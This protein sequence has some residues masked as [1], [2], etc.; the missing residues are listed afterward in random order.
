MEEMTPYYAQVVGIGVI[1]VTVHCIGMCGPIMASL[2]AATG[3]DRAESA[4]GRLWRA[5][6]AVLSYQGGRAVVYAALGAAAGAVGAGAQALIE[7]VAKTAGLVVAG[8]ILAAGVWKLLPLGALTSDQTKTPWAAK[9]TGW[10]LR[11]IGRRL[12]SSG[13]GRMAA[14]GF[15][16][17][18]LPCVLMFWVLGIAASTASVVHG[19]AIMVLLVA[20]TTPVL[21]A[22]ACGSSLPGVFRHL[23]SDRVI[24]GAM[25]VS[26]LWLALIAAAANGWIGH[27]HIPF[28]IRGRELVVMLW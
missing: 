26:G 16:L 15:V 11:R 13:P 22:A 3:V 20:M 14:F 24:G 7:D 1:W 5:L 6:K 23:R 2:T 25:L 12:P 9:W 28:E 19:A 8:A 17:G 27:L 18:F 4:R 10:A 21:V